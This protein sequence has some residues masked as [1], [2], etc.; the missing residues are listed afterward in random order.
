MRLRWCALALLACACAVLAG[1]AV[2]EEPPVRLVCPPD[3]ALVAAGGFDCLV[4]VHDGSEPVLLV[5]EAET[6]WT[7]TT[8]AGRFARLEL[9]A[10]EHTVTVGEQ[11]AHITA[12]EDEEAEGLMRTHVREG[13]PPDSC[14]LCH[15]PGEG[16]EPSIGNLAAPDACLA[17]HTHGEFDLAHFHPFAPLAHCG[18]CHALHGSARDSLLGA[19]AS[20]LCSGCHDR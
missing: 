7:T 20:E 11:T 12:T 6:A 19:P 17:C 13:D 10:G 9:P 15:A 16:E 4:R 2:E 1:D 18:N 14:L 5:D 8:E 3:G